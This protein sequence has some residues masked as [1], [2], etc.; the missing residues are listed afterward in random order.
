MVGGI[1]KRAVWVE[2]VVLLVYKDLIWHES[3]DLWHGSK[4]WHASKILGGSKVDAQIWNLPYPR[5]MGG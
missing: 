2:R 4:I 3:M 1:S 5:K